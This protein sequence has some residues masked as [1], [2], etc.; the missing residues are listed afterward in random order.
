[1]INPK[2]TAGKKAQP[3]V[4]REAK[5]SS[6]YTGKSKDVRSQSTYISKEQVWPRKRGRPTNPGL[7]LYAMSDG[8]FAVWDPHRNYWRTQDQDVGDVPERP[9]AYVFSPAEVWDGL[10]GVGDTWLCNG[11]IRDWAGWQKENGDPFRH[12]KE[13]LKALSPSG[14]EVLEPGKLTRVNL[15]DARDIPTI[16]MAYPLDVPILHASSGIRRIVALAYFLVW[17]WQEHQQAAVLVGEPPTNQI[18]FLIDEVEAHLH[19]TWQRTIIP[20]LISVVR[21]LSPDASVQLVATTH[22]P[23]IM[24]SVEP[25]FDP[26]SDAWFDLDYEQDEVKLQHRTFEK[27]GDAAGW[28]VSEAFDLK[29]GRSVEYEELTESASRLLEGENDSPEFREEVRQMNG[30]LAEALKPTDTFLF[31]WQYICRKKGWLK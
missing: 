3:S 22:S 19:P 5:I 12:L 16:R 9:S 8:S 17:A 27:H 11:L 15:D 1:E 31:N 2:L 23:L 26:S 28:L 30:K 29:S 20:A 21:N 25:L 6:S 4:G 14:K 18:T 7:V 13:V 24:A 10:R